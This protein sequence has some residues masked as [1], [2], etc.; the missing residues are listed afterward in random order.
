MFASGSFDFVLFS[1]NGIDYV[2]HSD[3][4]T[5]LKEI[6]RVLRPGGWFCFSTHN[7]NFCG[8]LFDLRQMISLNLKRTVKRL[9]LRFVYNWRVRGA[10]LGRSPHMTINDGTHS[11]QLLTYYIRPEAQLSQLAEYFTDIRVFSSV[12]G[13]EILG[14]NELRNVQDA[15]LYYLCKTG[16]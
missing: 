12:S 9:I 2:N 7:L 13:S 6:R 16:Q 8:Q 14:R 3:R 10:S 1:F 4:L 11:C 5:I 15:W